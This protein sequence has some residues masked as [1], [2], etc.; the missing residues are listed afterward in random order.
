M[1][2]ARRRC[3]A[4]VHAII[5]GDHEYHRLDPECPA[6]GG[7]PARKHHARFAPWEVEMSERAEVAGPEEIRDYIR[8]IIRDD[9]VAGRCETAV[10]RFPPEPNG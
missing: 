2:A 10:T 8:D 9:L 1:E 5:E 7:I 3:A 4:G 6:A